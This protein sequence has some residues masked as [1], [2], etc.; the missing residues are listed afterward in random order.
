MS[1]TVDSLTVQSGRDKD[2]QKGSLANK[3]LQKQESDK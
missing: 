1:H 2:K 3:Q